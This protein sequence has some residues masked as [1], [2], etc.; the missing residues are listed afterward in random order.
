MKKLFN[1]NIKKCKRLLSRK[2]KVYCEGKQIHSIAFQ[3]SIELKLTKIPFNFLKI[4][5]EQKNTVKR[6]LRDRQNLFV[7]TVKRWNRETKIQKK[8]HNCE[9]TTVKLTV[10]ISY[11]TTVKLTSLVGYVII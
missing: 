3:P 8:N 4:E 11:T 1:M 2:I 7:I 6:T 9:E 10:K 5:S